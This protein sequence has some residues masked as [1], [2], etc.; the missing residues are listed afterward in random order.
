MQRLKYASLVY[1]D[2]EINNVAH[3]LAKEAFCKVVDLVW[4]DDIPHCILHA[5]LRNRSCPIPISFFLDQYFS[6]N[7]KVPTLFKKKSV[8]NNTLFTHNCLCSVCC[9]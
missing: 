1:M 4:L 6:I 9:V 3:C 2:R 7:E 5:L 8:I